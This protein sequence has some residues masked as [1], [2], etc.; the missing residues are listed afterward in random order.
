[1]RSPAARHLNLAPCM[2]IA[3]RLAWPLIAPPHIS[4][5]RK[6]LSVS[7]ARAPIQRRL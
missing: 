2:V 7:A 3:A 6:L 1:V 4:H 5:A